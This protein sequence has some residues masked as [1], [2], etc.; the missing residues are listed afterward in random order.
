MITNALRLDIQSKQQTNERKIIKVKNSEVRLQDCIVRLNRLTPNQIHEAENSRSHNGNG[1][2][3]NGENFTVRI[4][5][6]QSLFNMKVSSKYF[7]ILGQKTVQKGV[8]TEYC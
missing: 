6:L 7:E 8:G 1:N 2:D 5:S 4:H 3:K